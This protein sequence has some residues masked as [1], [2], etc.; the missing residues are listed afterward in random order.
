MF[1]GIA[2]NA[3]NPRKRCNLLARALGVATRDNNLAAW[4]FPTDAADRGPCILI[5]R[6]GDGA[7]IQDHDFRSGR[8]GGSYQTAFLELALNRSAVGLRGAAAKILYVETRRHRFAQCL[9][10][11]QC[12]SNDVCPIKRTA[13]LAVQTGRH[14]YSNCHPS[15]VGV[16]VNKKGGRL[17]A[18]PHDYET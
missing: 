3:S 2:D 16:S 8:R 1:V 12:L 15:G 4:V 10:Q 9:S 17:R 5:S 7:R 14:S 18:R 6:S 13:S 11:F